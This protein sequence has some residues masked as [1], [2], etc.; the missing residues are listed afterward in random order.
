MVA[1][2]AN[3][4]DDLAERVAEGLGMA[5]PEP[6]PR[7]LKRLPKP[8]IQRSPALSLFARPGDGSIR[9][10]RAASL[11]A[12]GVDG[13]AAQAL[14]A[15]LLDQGAVPRYIG[16]RL[17][18]V[19]AA[20]GTEIEVDATFENMPSVLFDAAA[21]PGGKQAVIL[22]GGFGHALEFL[23]DQYRHAKPIAALGEAA[24]L[25]EGAGISPVLPSG[26][27]DPCLIVRK[28]SSADEVLP[29]FVTAIVQHRHHAR[30]T[31]PPLVSAAAPTGRNAD[32]VGCPR[33]P[34]D[35]GKS[36]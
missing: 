6:L 32:P 4:D 18:T 34:E 22:L 26:E 17:G 8:E 12:D 14:H 1:S 19:T 9:T 24:D 30:E 25:L 27:L 29:D 20:D 31:A 11:V 28:E 36:S 7:A 5:V 10:R 21:V 16:A 15:G 35:H 3:V 13:D 23:K 33:P 2:L